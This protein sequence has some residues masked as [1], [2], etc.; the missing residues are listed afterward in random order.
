MAKKGKRIRCTEGQCIA[1]PLT[2]GRFARFVVARRTS[3][4]YL[5]S[6][7]FP[8]SF[9]SIPVLA[10]FE[11]LKASEALCVWKISDVGVV[12]SLWPVVGTMP[13]WHREE[14]PVPKFAFTDPLTGRKYLRTFDDNDPRKLI[15]QDRVPDD[16]VFT[17]NKDGSRGHLIAAKVLTRRVTEWEER[18][19]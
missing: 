12:D 17:E 1:M 9:P 13:N 4:G 11:Q 19:L 14:W 7:C 18:N 16:Y 5:L 15:A 6:Y 2:N 3:T 8:P 10:D